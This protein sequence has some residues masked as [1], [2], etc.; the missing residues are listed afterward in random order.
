MAGAV[1]GM[2][3]IGL[4]GGGRGEDGELRME[5]GEGGGI[6]NRGRE[7]YFEKPVFALDAVRRGSRRLCVSHSAARGAHGS[8]APYRRRFCPLTGFGTRFFHERFDK[9]GKQC[10]GVSRFGRG[11]ITGRAGVIW[12]SSGG[13]AG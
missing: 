2:V 9:T 12:T 1:G 6:R 8:D 13:A 10:E 5:D 11:R 3:A 7:T 4:A